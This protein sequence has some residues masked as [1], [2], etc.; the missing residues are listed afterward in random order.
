MNDEYCAGLWESKLACEI[1]WCS[2]VPGLL[3]RPLTYQGPSWSWAGINGHIDLNSCT[4]A[5][6]SEY[7]SK[8]FTAV[9]K[10]FQILDCQV[11]FHCKGQK[12]T[13]IPDFDASKFGSV[14]SGHL[15]VRCQLRSAELRRKDKSVATYD[16]KVSISKPGNLK[17]VPGVRV[18]LDCLER[19]SCIPVFLVKVIT[20]SQR[21]RGLLLRKTE[22]YYSRIGI[23]VVDVKA[24]EKHESKSQGFNEILPWLETGEEHIIT[25]S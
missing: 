21:M 12:K 16:N 14:K 2:A 5:G 6:P 8:D 3:P 1:L 20:G 22:E 17:D 10:G 23:F 9:D 18:L 13:A 15:K 11:A 7:S 4:M 19:E 24:L 25:I